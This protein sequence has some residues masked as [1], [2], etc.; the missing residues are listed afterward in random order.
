MTAARSRQ[1]PSEH[2]HGTMFRIATICRGAL[3]TVSSKG[4][5]ATVRYS[6]GSIQSLP[7]SFHHCRQKLLFHAALTYSRRYALFTL[8]GIAGEDDLD[9]PD[10]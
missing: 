10:L 7:P 5:H 1:A 4:L 9:A 3:R 2:R 8:V 6:G